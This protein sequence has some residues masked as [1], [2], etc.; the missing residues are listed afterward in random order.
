[1][2]I[3]RRY[4]IRTVHVNNMATVFTTESFLRNKLSN[5]KQ[6]LI[7]LGADERQLS[8]IEKYLTG[9]SLTSY[10]IKLHTG[11]HDPED[12]V[13]RIVDYSGVQKRNEIRHTNWYGNT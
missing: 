11:E 4:I 8:T 9:S 5:M 12:I 7:E 6:K 13:N 1:M 3:F 10:A 2:W